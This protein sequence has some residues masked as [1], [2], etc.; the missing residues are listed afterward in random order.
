MKVSTAKEAMIKVAT[1]SKM[2]LKNT[3]LDDNN[4]Y[5]R[6]E[7]WL[8]PQDAFNHPVHSRVVTNPKDP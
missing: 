2:E 5:G 8:D 7:T 6:T 3:K 4:T 1:M